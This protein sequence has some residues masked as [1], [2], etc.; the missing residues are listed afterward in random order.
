MKSRRCWLQYSKNDV[1]ELA[2]KMARH[3]DDISAEIPGATAAYD[4]FIQET[5]NAECIS[6]KVF[7]FPFHGKFRI[8]NR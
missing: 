3:M 1:A 5:R 2:F 6:I 7:L 4:S 8:F